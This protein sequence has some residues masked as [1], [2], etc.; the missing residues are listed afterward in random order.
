M[1]IKEIDKNGMVAKQGELK[2]GDVI[3]KVCIVLHVSSKHSFL[4]FFCFFFCSSVLFD[5]T[6]LT[7]NDTVTYVT[8]STTSWI[9]NDTDIYITY[10]T[11]S[12]ITYDTAI[13]ISYS[14]SKHSACL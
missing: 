4:F 14:N 12:N 3:L 2:S 7:R 10:S 11:L 8:Y 6:S 5:I 9:T 13:N 1:F